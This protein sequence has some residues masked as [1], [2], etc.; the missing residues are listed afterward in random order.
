MSRPNLGYILST[1]QR[2]SQEGILRK[3]SLKGNPRMF[4]PL[5]NVVA[6]PIYVS[7]TSFKLMALRDIMAQE[8]LHSKN[9]SVTMRQISHSV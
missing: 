5:Y 9:V 8:D 2:P 1:F 3:E 7:T 4:F 6:S